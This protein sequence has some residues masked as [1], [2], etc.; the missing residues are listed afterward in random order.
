MDEDKY[1]FVRGVEIDIY[2][3]MMKHFNQVVD[4][5]DFEKHM[6]KI[7]KPKSNTFRFLI[8]EKYNDY[9]DNEEAVGAYRMYIA[10]KF[11][12]KGKN[13]KVFSDY[14]KVE[15]IKFMNIKKNKEMKFTEKYD[16]IKDNFVLWKN[17]YKTCIETCSKC[18]SY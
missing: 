8:L 11:L 5:K 18:Y 7:I 6:I 3:T 1:V 17:E 13:N 12:V 15:H 16:K 9:E 2:Q 10:H 4:I 14:D